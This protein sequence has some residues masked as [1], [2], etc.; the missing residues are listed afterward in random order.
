MGVGFGSLLVGVG[1]WVGVGVEVRP[2][3]ESGIWAEFSECGAGWR[4]RMV[5]FCGDDA[6]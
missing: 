5:C 2:G 1:D 3:A 4:S 6:G